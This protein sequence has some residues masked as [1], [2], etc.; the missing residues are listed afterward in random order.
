[1]QFKLVDYC[2]FSHPRAMTNK[3]LRQQIK[4]EL[5]I[6][7]R[8]IDN[9][10]LSALAAVQLLFQKTQP[11]P[12]ALGLISSAQYFSIELLQNL[13]QEIEQGH[14]IKPL[15]FV[16]TVGNA[17]NY[18]IA[19]QFAMN[20]CN[21][22]L[23]ISENAFYK[24]SLLAASELKQDPS[25]QIILVQWHE[26][27]TERSCTASLLSAA[28]TASQTLLIPQV[29]HPSEID[30]TELPINIELAKVTF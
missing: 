30:P 15:D 10:T 24:S 22:F 13:I 8:R 1:M 6:S 20:A 18:Y 28:E 4:S 3:A 17:A 11:N 16:A 2:Q 23:G 9:F 12:H 14:A 7:G 19:K 25:L 26:S 21:L 5:G 29:W 27:E